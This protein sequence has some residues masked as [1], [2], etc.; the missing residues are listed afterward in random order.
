MKR[1]ANHFSALTET[2][3]GSGVFTNANYSVRMQQVYKHPN[4]KTCLVVNE[5]IPT[6][7]DEDDL[8]RPTSCRGS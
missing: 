6:D 5:P 2:S 3:A 7:L 4:Y 8:A 1:R